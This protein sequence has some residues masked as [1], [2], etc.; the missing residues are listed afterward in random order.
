MRYSLCNVLVLGD[1]EGHGVQDVVWRVLG[2]VRARLHEV[3][4]K[5]EAVEVDPSDIWVLN[6]VLAFSL[7]H[8]PAVVRKTSA[9]HLLKS[10]K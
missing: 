3:E 7:A 8:H 10:A 6:V 1:L 5:G 9:S 4:V 2:E